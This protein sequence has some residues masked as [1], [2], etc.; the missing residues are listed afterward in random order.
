MGTVGDLENLHKVK[1]RLEQ[2]N[3]NLQ[4]ENAELRRQKTKGDN[5][6]AKEKRLST[7]DSLAWKAHAARLEREVKEARA[8]NADLAGAK[9]LP[10]TDA[11]VAQ[12]AGVV[13]R[14]RRVQP[15]VAWRTQE[16]PARVRRLLG[17]LFFFLFL[18]FSLL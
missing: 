14:Q 12:F 18:V 4:D 15:G 9:Q 3:K 10:I 7:A 16:P 17:C 8:A 1:F 11:S 6:L 5:E 13:G 2:A